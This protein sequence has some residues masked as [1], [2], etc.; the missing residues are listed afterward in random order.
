M[1]PS[2]G[3]TGSDNQYAGVTT[4]VSS[5]LRQ[6]AHTQSGEYVDEFIDWYFPTNQLSPY[7]L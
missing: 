7:S 3:K 6:L 1:P 5:Q 4:I 2:S